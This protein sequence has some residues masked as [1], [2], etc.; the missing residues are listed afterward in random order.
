MVSGNSNNK[1]SEKAQLGG[2]AIIKK[3]KPTSAFLPDSSNLK[4]DSR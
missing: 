2:G 1:Y 4:I 3:A